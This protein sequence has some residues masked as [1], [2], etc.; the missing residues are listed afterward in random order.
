M[1]ILLYVY[2]KKAILW[3]S[4]IIPGCNGSLQTIVQVSEKDKNIGFTGFGIS[5]IKF[6]D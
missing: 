4:L 2:V 1:N 5:L 6:L 3:L